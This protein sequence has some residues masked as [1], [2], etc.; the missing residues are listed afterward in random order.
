ISF[1]TK[2]FNFKGDACCNLF[3][4]SYQRAFDVNDDKADI[5]MTL[6]LNRWEGVNLKTLPFLE[7]L[8]SLFV[9]M[10]RGWELFTSLEINGTKVFV[11][12]G[13]RVDKWE[14]VLDTASLLNY[15]TCCSSLA[16]YFGWD[17]LF[18]SDVTYTSDEHK[19]ISEVVEIV[20]GRQVC[21]RDSI[22]GN[23]VSEMLVDSD[24]TT[25]I[26]LKEIDRPLTIRVADRNREELELFGKRVCLP[27]RIITLDGVMPIMHGELESLKEGDVVSVE[28][29][30]QADFRCTIEYESRHQDM[31]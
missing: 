17:I 20:E 30:P 2:T 10:S 26:A 8:H 28:W 16:Q 6:C 31:E 22:S 13:A 29:E 18:V 3:S 12:K 14:Y 7:K 19:K 25:A 24:L 9:R 27:S 21:D 4:L 1:G 11:S 5:T 23:F 15:V